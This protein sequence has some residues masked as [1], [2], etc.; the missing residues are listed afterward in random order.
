VHLSTDDQRDAVHRIPTEDRPPVE[1][2]QPFSDLAEEDTGPELAAEPATR[3]GR[4]QAAKVANRVDAR[5]PRSGELPDVAR[6]AREA[7]GL[8]PDLSSAARRL[9]LS[10]E[11]ELGPDGESSAEGRHSR[12]R[13]E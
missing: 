7:A 12:H 11:A 13:R 3:Q 9:R 8:S 4:R 5:G 2:S 1:A 6:A 10:R